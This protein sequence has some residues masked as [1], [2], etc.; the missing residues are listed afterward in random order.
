M[1]GVP[2]A[3]APTEV[4]EMREHMDPQL[5]R[6]LALMP[7]IDLSDIKAIRKLNQGTVMPVPPGN[8]LVSTTEILIPRSDATSVRIRICRPQQSSQP[9]PALLYCHPGLIFGTLDMDHARCLRFASDVGCVVVSVEYRLAPE[10]PFPAGLEDCYAILAWIEANATELNADPSRIAVAG[11][12]TGATLAAAVALLARDRGGPP[13]V[14]QL[15]VCPALDDRLQTASM[16]EFAEAEPM[17]AGRVGARHLWR[18]YL[19]TVDGDVSPYAAPARAEDVSRLPSTFLITAEFD[20][21]RDEGLAYGLRLI[22]AGVPTELHHFPGC[23]HAFDLVARTA[24]I[25][26][27]AVDE[28]VTALRRALGAPALAEIAGDRLSAGPSIE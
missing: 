3:G 12:S 7:V 24:T 2:Q 19:G 16:A 25:S 4:I 18:Q 20:C 8:E 23:F 22:Q 17:E 13:L 15:L 28:Q 26:Q 27:R 9:M 11:C 6:I 10:H 1:I 14:F 5:A 21:L